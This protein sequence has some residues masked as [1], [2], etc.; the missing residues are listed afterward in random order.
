LWS[1]RR[2]T[3]LL[4]IFALLI[5]MFVIT[6]F[7]VRSYHARERS[8][9][10]DWNSRGEAELRAG[11]A[12]AAIADFRNAL[13]H[14]R[15]NAL[16][17]LRLAQ[18]LAAT[19]HF[20]E[21]RNYLM[22][23]REREPGNGPV[24]LELARLA[25]REHVIP[26]ALRYFHDAVYSEWDGDP[27]V[28]RRAVRLEL[29]KFLLESDQKAAARAELIA[30]AGNLPP[31]AELHTQVGALLV[32]AG[33]Y[34]DALR[35]FRQALAAEPHSAPALA[36]AGEC[37]FQTG[38]YAQ[39][40]RYLDRAL[41]EDAHLTRT[42][43]MLDTT[44]AVLGL[45]P[46]VRRLGEQE[47][48][49]RAKQ[50]FDQAMTRLEA[51]A[52]QRGIQLKGPGGDTL[53]KLNAEATAVQPRARESTFR[54][55]PGLLFNVMDLAFEIERTTAQVCGEPQGQDLALLLIAQQQE[56]GRP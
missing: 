3:F 26:E 36:G 42:A 32:K 46:F 13:S 47:R 5:L 56:G 25:V 18:A 21:A 33:G 8:L 30:V 40:Q 50:D 9:A 1:L 4:V 51:C 38:Q 20:Q 55:D 7:A 39:A 17:Q 14:A 16:Y 48:A 10:Q 24:N 12:G 35:V 15:D 22:N 2:D 31:E 53:Q 44:R 45:N 49:R 54:H 34:D 6:G 23:L 41:Q 11:N 27:V 29:V 19:A 37:Y 43:A 28:Q 52:A